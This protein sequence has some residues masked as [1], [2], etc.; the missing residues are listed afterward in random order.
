METRSEEFNLCGEDGKFTLIT[1]LG[2]TATWE[3]GDTDDISSSQLLMLF[4]ELNIACGVLSLAQNLELDA[5]SAEIVEEQ[6]S[7]C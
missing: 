5:F 2:V 6:L 3:S 1:G 4:S 7:T